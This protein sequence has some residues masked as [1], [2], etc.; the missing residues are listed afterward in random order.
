MTATILIF[1]PP[2]PR[3][4]FEAEFL[5]F[6]EGAVDAQGAPILGRII[7][8]AGRREPPV[9]GPSG[10]ANLHPYESRSA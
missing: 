4:P 5:A 8:L 9:S 3:E 2:P 7:S 1:P 10:E 6:M